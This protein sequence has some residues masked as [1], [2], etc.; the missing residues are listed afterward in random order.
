M[1]I[2]K[3]FDKIFDEEVHSDLLKF[4]RGEFKDRYLVEV[5]KQKDKYAIKTSA[6]YANFLVKRSLEGVSGSLKIKGVIICTFDLRAE[7][8]FEFAKVKNFQGI[9]QIV[10]DTEVNAEEI[11]NLMKKYPR[12][13][14][15]LSFSTGKSD[16]KIKAK[17]PKSAKP[18][19]KEGGAKA[20]FC[21]L[22]TSD[23]EVLG[24]LLFDVKGEWKEIKV[25]HT[26]VVEEIIYPKDAAKM[27]P[28]E[29]REKSKRKGKVIRNLDV[30]GSKKISEACFEA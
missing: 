2:K 7:L 3:I 6:E 16:L 1:V 29:V 27:K 8:G 25:N 5:K 18:G 9:R 26:I 15:A 14:F 20:V 24:D 4:S 28:E 23:K 13:F 19:T 11:L 10:I 30:D 17:A 22:K 12:V 21:S